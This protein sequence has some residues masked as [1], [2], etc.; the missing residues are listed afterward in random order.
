M[1]Y[2]KKGIKKGTI[3][4]VHGNSS[5]A[6]EYKALLDSIEIEYTVVSIDLNGHG[7]NQIR[8]TS[9]FSF[10]SQKEFIM[11]NVAEIND[12][13]L[14]IGNSLGGHLAIEIA[15]KIERIRGLVIMG[16][17]PLKK[18]LNLD[19]AFMPIVELGTFFTEH[20]KEQELLKTID[21]VVK[22]KKKCSVI[23]EDFHIANPLV[24]KSLATDVTENNM[25]D[26]FEIFTN[27]EIPKYIIVGDSDPTVKRNYLDAVKA[28][29]STSCSILEI[30][31]CGHYPSIERP[32]E[33]NRLI[34]K[35][36]REVFN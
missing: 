23:I 15:T 9:A 12:D 30:K 1:Q 7:N 17:P 8:N 4:C 33:F 2:R 3:F 31:E 26:Q 27:L 35:I 21:I 25:L 5:S 34:E 24:R 18:P 19:E 13:I 20:P 14:L 36:S 29:C 6:N 22:N 10:E 32:N 28:Q 16:A 11:K